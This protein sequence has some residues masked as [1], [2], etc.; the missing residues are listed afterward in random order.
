[1]RNPLTLIATS[2][3]IGIMAFALLGATAASAQVCGDAN[4]NDEV[5]VTDGVQAL[6]DAAGLSSSCEDGCDVDGNGSVTVS[7]GVNIL[8]KAAG[9]AINEACDFTG[10]EANGVVS[11]TMS[12][13]G[14]MTKVPGVGASSAFAA[15]GECE[16]DGTIQVQPGTNANT[17][18][19]FTDCEI[20]GDIIDGTIG[21]VVLA[22]G[23]V[24]G[25][26]AFTITHLK[27]GESHSFSGQLAIVNE[28]AGKRLNGTLTVASSKRGT[29][30]IQ[31]TRILLTGDGSVRQGDL[32]YDFSKTTFGKILRIRIAFD[33]GDELPAT[34]QL[35]N[36]QVR[37]FI[38]DRGTRILV[39]AV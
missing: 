11:P 10:S 14:A 7:D 2:L 37:Q 34:V 12:I 16:N 19:L 6:R 3:G 26:D 13:F 24:L 27:N 29:F 21:R 22:Q 20:D 17:S 9:I 1:M 38:L 36:Q 18:V 8:R 32:V 23:V 4:A 33:D 31:F 35:R 28:Q 25:F 30:T 39:P 15:A 5:T